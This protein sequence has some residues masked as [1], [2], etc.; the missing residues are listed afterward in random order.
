MQKCDAIRQQMIKEFPPDGSSKPDSFYKK[1]DEA[2][3]PIPAAAAHE[4]TLRSQYLV[5]GMGDGETKSA[6]LEA[7]GAVFEL[8]QLFCHHFQAALAKAKKY[9]QALEPL[10]CRLD[11][12][13]AAIKFLVAKHD[14]PAL[15]GMNAEK[16]NE[17]F[18]PV[19][20]PT[21]D[22]ALSPDVI[23]NGIQGVCSS[24]GKSQI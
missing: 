17:G 19:A 5:K 6:W 16:S 15:N 13:N 7:K 21:D 12:V 2:K 20:A 24:S 4:F 14:D 8:R 18:P 1:L 9:K 23:D 3:K 11:P 10:N 22:R